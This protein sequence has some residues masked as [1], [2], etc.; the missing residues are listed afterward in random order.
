MVGWD[1]LG[2]QSP[3][4]PESSSTGHDVADSQRGEKFVSCCL[5]QS[6]R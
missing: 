3:L 5:K 4:Y 2:M 1:V 6:N